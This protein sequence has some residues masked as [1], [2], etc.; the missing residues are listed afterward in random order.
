MLWKPPE[1]E[2]HANWLLHHILLEDGLMRNVVQSALAGCLALLL[3]PERV[4]LDG[5][6]IGAP[7]AAHHGSLQLANEDALLD[8]HGSLCKL[9]N[10]VL[11]T[12]VRFR[13]CRALD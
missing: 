3:L 2:L 9:S 11:V 1:S 10:R 6:T 5:F 12:E 7:A 13:P 4:C 8:A